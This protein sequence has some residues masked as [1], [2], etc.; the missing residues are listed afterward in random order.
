MREFLGET[1]LLAKDRSVDESN[2]AFAVSIMPNLALTMKEQGQLSEAESKQEAGFLIATAADSQRNVQL[3]ASAIT[4]LGVLKVTEAC[5]L[6][7]EL[8]ADSVNADVPAVARP[9]CLSLMRID[10]ERA[11]PDLADVLK[12]TSDVRVF[13]TAAFAL[14]QLKKIECMAVL[15]EHLGRFPDSGACDAAL[16]EMEDIVYGVLKNPLDENPSAAIQATR[17]LWREG[18]SDAY[19]P[20]LRNLLSEASLAVR[21]AAAERLLERASCLDFD[22][23]KREL[24]LVSKAIG[25]QPEL[26]EYQHRIRN[27]LSA[28]VL[29][30]NTNSVVPAPSALKLDNHK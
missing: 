21:R 23:E 14:A 24:T 12:R 26:Q 1:T 27:R 17:F 5:V 28:S 20:L 8:L 16:V 29:A 11:I 6:L 13:G 7:R 19:V 30:P 2:S 3:R 15:L 22:S 25:D 18:Q 4:A 9:A 10:G